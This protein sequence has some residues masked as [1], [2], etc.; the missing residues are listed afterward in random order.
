MPKS[1]VKTDGYKKLVEKIVREFEQLEV[2]VKNSVAKGHWNV[3]KYIDEHLLEHKDRADYATGFYEGLARDTDR[4]MST[5]QRAVQFF[6]AYPIPAFP[7]ELTWEHFKG[8]ITVRDIR[9]R[10]KLEERI[11]RQNWDTQKFRK[12]LSVRRKL[13]VT[14]DGKP[15]AQLAFS[16]GRLQTYG[17]VP[18]NKSLLHQG[19]LALDLGFREQYSIPPDAPRL[20]ENDTVELV[21]KEGE[22]AGVRKVEV[23]EEELF[24]YK[25]AVE[26]IIDAD[27]LLVSF[28]FQ[29]P[30]SVSQKLRLRGIDCPEIDTPEG[31]RAK[32]FVEARIKDCDFIVVKTYK[33]RSDK[34]DRYLADIFCLAGASDPAVVAREGR[35][36]NQELL[37]EGLA[38]AY[39]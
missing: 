17:I 33:D 26:K 27:T 8:L 28:D 6:R 21:L 29:C 23:P 10:K 13:A 9:E 16:R 31:R 30:M 12:Y 25:A 36:L 37:D 14:D 3:G 1:L 7:R 5:L 19:P 2:L 34:F 15:V 20:K 18:A 35:Y 4:D 11:I 39:A 22:L 38:A 32:R 24:T